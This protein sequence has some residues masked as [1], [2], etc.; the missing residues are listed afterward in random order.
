MRISKFIIV[1]CLLSLSEALFG[2]AY[3]QIG[4]KELGDSLMAYT[5]FSTLWSP[6]VRVKNMRVNGDRITLYTNTTLRD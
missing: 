5:G 3:A 1:F 2:P 4:M 6:T